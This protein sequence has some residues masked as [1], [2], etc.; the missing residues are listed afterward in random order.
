LTEGN[1]S[2]TQEQAS[3]L[4][5]WP[6]DRPV[7][8]LRELLQASGR[9]SKRD[10][11]DWIRDETDDLVEVAL[12]R[13][14]IGLRPDPSDGAITL[15][16]PFTLAE[17][18]RR[19]AEA[20]AVARATYEGAG[21]IEEIINAE[22]FAVSFRLLTT[23]GDLADPSLGP[24]AFA[25]PDLPDYSWDDPAPGSWIVAE[26]ASARLGPYG[27]LAPQVLGLDGLPA[28]LDVRLD[29]L[30]QQ[31]AATRLLWLEGGELL[32]GPPGPGWL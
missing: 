1:E 28:P 24:S 5:E 6:D 30:R 13:D 11:I 8:N 4:D 15:T 21:I 22:G 25:L 16:Y 9:S 26:Y 19:W 14:G 7:N 17:L 27:A 23:A 32:A 18:S 2:L 12:D 29:A 3:E 20:E 31:M 10:V